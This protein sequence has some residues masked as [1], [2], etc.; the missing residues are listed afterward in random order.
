MC[1]T[2]RKKHLEAKWKDGSY[3]TLG[4][5]SGFRSISGIGFVVSSEWSSKVIE[6]ALHSSRTGKLLISIGNS[7]TLK[8]IQAYAPTSLL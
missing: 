7:R 3:I 1:E 4:E 2:R 6:C 8:I 5:G